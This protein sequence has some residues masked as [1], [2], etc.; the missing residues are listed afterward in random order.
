MP[1][2]GVRC[3]IL[4]HVIFKLGHIASGSLN[5]LSFHVIKTFNYILA[6]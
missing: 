5:I 3:G 4:I 6:T 1:V 2:N